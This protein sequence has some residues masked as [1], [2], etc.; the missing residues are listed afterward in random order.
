VNPPVNPPF[1]L[2]VD[3]TLPLQMLLAFLPGTPHR[4]HMVDIYRGAKATDA[5][6][7]MLDT[8]TIVIGDEKSVTAAIDRHGHG[9]PPASPILARAQELAATHD[10][11]MIASDDLSKFQPANTGFSSPMA[12]Q[13]KGVEMGV[14]VRDGFQFEMS[15][16][17]ESSAMAEQLTQ[18]ISMQLT[19]AQ[20][21]NP[22]TAEVMRKLQVGTEGNRLR[23]SLSLTK[24]ELEQNLRTMQA[25]RM[26]AAVPP[27]STGQTQ[28]APPKPKTPGKIRIYGLDEGVR[29]IPLTK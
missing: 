26:A 15:L 2:M 29:E 20:A 6:I 8:R 18:L 7:A 21:K 22:E 4:Y 24:E 25:T 12:G 23:M 17:T 28:A 1:L 3:G 13:I 10:F 14:A 16:A 5:S 27:Q 9:M 19:A 11:W